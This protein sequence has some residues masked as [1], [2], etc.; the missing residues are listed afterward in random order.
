MTSIF[1]C[2]S[3]T[4]NGYKNFYRFQKGEGGKEG[5]REGGR[6][7]GGRKEGRKKGRREGREE[8]HQRAATQYQRNLKLSYRKNSLQYLSC[9]YGKT[10]SPG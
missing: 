9:K 1:I 7:E 3:I 5:G 8:V 6:K 2:G 4:F 10:Q